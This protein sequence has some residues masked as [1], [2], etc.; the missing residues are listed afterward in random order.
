[1]LP[2]DNPT[3]DRIRTLIGVLSGTLKNID[4]EFEL[5]LARVQS[6][7]NPDLRP[8]ILSTVQRRHMQRREPYVRHL[9]ELRRSIGAQ[10]Q[11]HPTCGMGGTAS[12]R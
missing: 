12:A 8:M 9:A 6:S 2:N 5:E 3:E 4:A 1:M 10:D 11:H 7:A